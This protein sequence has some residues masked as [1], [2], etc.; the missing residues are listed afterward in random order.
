MSSTPWFDGG[1]NTSVEA[2]WEDGERV[3]SRRWRESD[4]GERSAFLAVVPVAEHPTPGCLER[5]QHEYQLKDELDPS[6]AVQPLDLVRERGKAVLVLADPGGV[7]LDRLLG[8]PMEIGRFLRVA[9]A[10]SGALGGVHR[11][12]L[13]HKDIKPAH[14]LVD[15]AESRV[16]L[17]G[18]GI[19]SRLPRERQAPEP[20]EFIAG[21]LA[22]MAP[23]QTGRMN[24]SIDSRSDLYALGVT[25]YQML[26]GRLPFGGADAM[27]W[28]HCHVARKP[29]PPA[30]RVQTIPVPI[31]EIIVKLLAKTA[32]DRYQTAA[33]VEHDLRRCLVEW[34]RH[35]RVEPFALGERDVSDQLRI[36]EKLYGRECEVEALLAAFERVV[37]TGAPELVLVSGYSGIGKSS[38][39]HELQKALVPQRGLFA[40]GKFDQFKRDIPYATL[41]QALQSLLRSLLSKSDA[42]LA[43][44]R[45]A[46]LAA[47]APNAALMNDLI[48]EL[49]LIVGE[50]PPVAE[51]APQEALR[52]FQVVLRR[53]IG[54]FARRE[55]PFA[56]FLDDLQWLD[57]AT[58]DFLEDLTAGSDLQH[59]MLIGAYRDNEVSAA[60]PLMRKLE[61]MRNTGARIEEIT[62]GPL[63]PEHLEQLI[64]DALRCEPE[65]AAGLARLVRE[66]TGGNPFF[67]NR[68]LYA[69]AEEGLLSFDHEGARWSWDLARI[70]AKGYT[71]NVAA[72]MVGK[73]RRLP[74][75]T[76]VALQ[77]LA[78]LGSNADVSLL[79]IALGT[80]EPTLHANLWEAVRHELI[81]RLGRSYRFVH[82]RIQEATYSLIG[83]EA[84]AEAH[85]RIGRLLLAHTP[86]EK[87]EELIFEI[88]GQLNRGAALIT[89]PEEREQLAE[90]NLIAGE[91]A[92]ASTAY[93]SALSYF[94][95]GSG[96]LPDDRWE[97]LHEHAFAL[98][99]NRAEC[100][101]L[102]GELAAAEERFTALSR[103]AQNTIERAR[104]SCLR[105]DLYVTLGQSS[106]AIE[107]GLEY[108]QHTGIAWSPH[109]TD[110]DVRS[111]YDRIWSRLGS[112]TIE[113]LVDLPLM[114]DPASLATIDVL[115]KIAPPA[116]F[117][118]T[119]SNLYALTVCR[120]VNLS[121]ERGNSDGSCD[122]YVRLGLLLGERFEDYKAGFRFGELARALVERRG[123]KRFQ[124][125]TYM[126]LGAHLYPCTKHVRAGIELVRRAFEI[127]NRN[128]D[129]SFAAYSCFNLT[130]V[131]LAA[132]EELTEVERE[133]QHGIEFAHKINFADV[134]DYVLSDMGLVR[135]LRGL[136]S[137][138]G[139]LDDDQF[140]EHRFEEHLSPN[141]EAV[142]FRYWIRKLQARFHAG[143]YAIAVDAETWARRRHAS[144][145]LF[146]EAA[147][148]HFYGALS[149]AACASSAGVDRQEHLDALAAHQERLDAWAANC[150]ENFESRAALVAAELARLEGRDLDAMRRY[151]QAI[152]SACANG[153]VQVEALAS[154][155][156][157]GFYAT[158]GFE[159]IARVY[160]HDARRGYLRW[161]ADGKVRQLDHLHPYLR[162]DGRVLGGPTS[163]IGAPIEQL[164]LSTVIKVS[165]AASSEIVLE[166]LLESLM[167]MAI[168]QAG[169][170]RGLLLIARKSEL[171]VA[172]KATTAGDSVTI[173]LCD[174]CVTSATL[175][176]ALIRYVV[177]THESVILDDAVAQPLFSQ[178]SYIVEHRARSILGLPLINQ[179]KL[180]GVLYL[181]NNLAAHAFA[182]A[183]IAVLKLLASQAAI[184]LENSHLYRDLAEREAKIRRLVDANI[185]GIFIWDLG[186][187]ILDANDVF[188]RIVG[189]EREDIASG[190]L[191][192]RALTPGEWLERDDERRMPELRSTGAVLPY[193]KEYYRKDGSRVPVLI[194]VASLEAG[195]NEGVAFVLD[196][197]ERRA[198]EEALRASEEQWK[199]AF[200][201]N[202]VMYFMLDEASTIVSVN[203]FGAEQL[204]FTTDELVG[205][206]VEV[207]FHEA[208][209]VAAQKNVAICLEQPGRTLSWELRK[210]RRN[211]QILWVRETARAMSIKGRPVL[212]VAC[213]DITEGKRAGEALRDM[214]M[215]LAHANRVATMG[216]LT[217][218]IAH[219]VSQPIAATVTNAEAALRW[220]DA[221]VPDVEEARRAI[222]RI[223]KA[224]SRA[225]D[226]VGRIRAL[227]KRAPLQR[228][229]FDIHDA[230]REVVE[231]TRGEALKNDV[232]LRMEFADTVPLVHGDRVQF[233]QVILNLII[234]A[235]EALSSV[236]E[237]T[238]ELQI[239]TG[240]EASGDPLVAV[241]DSGPG[242]EPATLERLFEPFYTTKP[243]GLGMGLSICRSIIE[244]QGGRLWATPNKPRGAS[245][246]FT[247]SSQAGHSP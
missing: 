205:R 53:F 232:S 115:T 45:E 233:Q 195:G 242:L 181:E 245:F 94:I 71:D 17:T 4:R 187:Q 30:E 151:E 118:P 21:T 144:A 112:R 22:Y 227:I 110:E 190:R 132:G 76:A 126:L 214:Q 131:L 173:H 59:V 136:T 88:V 39:V 135:T 199:A 3:F 238:R 12:G 27:E 37:A 225:G 201:N 9:I 92:K 100:E 32:E 95:A 106:R 58:L 147:D 167:R 69:L 81:E 141:V 1:A 29:A 119:G 128:G 140:D 25:F 40:V 123:L 188:L 87:R 50:Q 202:P 5:L 210:L 89:A 74:A 155:L 28:V 19:A 177:R 72:L 64:A 127:A 124:A 6:W 101:F 189:Y 98:E 77:Q 111:E 78:C 56:L 47:L 130:E 51:L 102:T 133:A 114:T 239:S 223:V 222:G 125:R 142:G 162:E 163:T 193:E 194:G 33:S 145:V 36:P 108:L 42:E 206:P 62:L 73:L 218:S 63:A 91:R 176:E 67:A 216:Q 209:R 161:G 85:L 235:I 219:E 90:L 185:I 170:E 247:L 116:W 229:R 186:G 220:L 104:A 117:S 80:S 152:E 24:R 182:P 191:S 240:R 212:L 178:D 44:W 237:G 197:T 99:L 224:G 46:L 157:A 164:D 184:S 60:H 2:L 207:L 134:I 26:T 183:G 168:E 138:F 137:S 139:S 221:R 180:A 231:L 107:V 198:A 86:R 49:E 109:P 203:P 96:L 65:G 211:G 68:F 11:R 15:S 7:P 246:Q 166:K 148:Y 217:A 79:S 143:D 14:V 172:A 16:W 70:R 66:K 41:V 215:Q 82:D 13:I 20:P 244:V 165:Q 226:V 159:K 169:A 208:D 55:H 204:G 35:A 160:L 103:R 34:E 213:E 38:V 31:S 54:V 129:L 84:R 243:G 8:A 196:L 122:A 179:G 241:R 10:L 61:S 153:F 48:P 75:Q 113:D 192:W 146:F 120:A 149:R 150:P 43:S 18:F 175:P 230:I 57:A 200:E 23:E 105:L 228:D 174:E 121:L 171:R 234:N 93:A 156:A 158:R 83:E 97:R 236:R 52:R 154:E